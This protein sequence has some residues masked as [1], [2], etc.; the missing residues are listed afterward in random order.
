MLKD[1]G[2]AT[3]E[4]VVLLPVLAVCALGAWQVL[5]VAWA[6]LAAGDAAHAGARALLSSEPARPAARRALPGSMRSGLTVDVAG[7]QVR[8]TVRV[9]SVIPGFSPRITATADVVHG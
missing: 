7:G 6:L 4:T 5:V 8:V 2:Q 3:I 9:P 1:R